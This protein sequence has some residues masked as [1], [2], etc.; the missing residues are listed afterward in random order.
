MGEYKW[1]GG[2]GSK[3]DRELNGLRIPPPTHGVQEIVPKPLKIQGI[4]GISARAHVCKELKVKGMQGAVC[5]TRYA[6]GW[7]QGQ[8]LRGG[9]SSYQPSETYERLP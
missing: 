6:N 1:Q 9:S 7:R 3:G 4:G 8:S 5:G 2:V